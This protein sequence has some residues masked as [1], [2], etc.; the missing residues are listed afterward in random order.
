MVTREELK[1]HWNLVKG[2][3]QE[4]WGQL[5]DEDLSRI[6][7]GAERLVGAI[8]QKT[9]ATRAE[10]E[11]LLSRS[12]HDASGMADQALVAA[13]EYAS[14]ASEALR[15]GYDQAAE[16]AAELTRRLTE[17]MRSK[18]GQTA[19]IAFGIGLAAGALLM[20]NRR[21]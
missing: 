1:G 7:G 17:T 14:E 8:Q 2:R 15:G 21:R 12:V 20:M 4:R 10:I 19:L 13:R 5:T 16:S 3:L 6:E 18:A 11:Q 9:G